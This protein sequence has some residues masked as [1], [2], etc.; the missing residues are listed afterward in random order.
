MPKLRLKSFTKILEQAQ[1]LGPVACPAS[2]SH[3]EVGN[4]NTKEKK[5]KKTLSKMVGEKEEANE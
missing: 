1:C 2:S 5:K 3:I 4:E